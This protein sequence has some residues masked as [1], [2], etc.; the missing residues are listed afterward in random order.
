MRVL[1]VNALF[2]DPSAALVVDGT[3]VAAAEEERFSRRKHGKRPVPFS[4]WELPVAGDALVPGAGRL[5]AAGPRRGG[6]LVRSRPGQARTRHGPVRPVGPPADHVRREGS[7]LPRHRAARASSAS[8]CGSSPTTS[9]MPPRPGSPPR[10]RETGRPTSVLVLDGRGRVHLPSRRSL[11]GRATGDVRRTGPAA[12]PRAA[13]RVA[14]RAPGVPA[15]ERRVQGDGAGV[16]RQ[17]APPGR[18]CARPIHATGDGGFVAPVPD[19]SQW[20]PAA[21]RRRD[22]VGSR[23]RRPRRVGAARVWR[24]CWSRW[25]AGCTS[26]PE[27]GP[28]PWPAARP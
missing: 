3:I 4:A 8:R 18:S 6:L 26:A 5:A 14:D 21:W 1:G 11:R 15:L 13:V 2:H 28:W 7:R 25:P 23:A 20:A 9:P 10:S 12:L 22:G 19:W 17:A 16:V 24:R 27:T